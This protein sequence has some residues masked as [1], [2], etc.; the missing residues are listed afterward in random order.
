[1][2]PLGPFA[3]YGFTF[4]PFLGAAVIYDRVTRGRI[5]PA[6]LWGGGLLIA[7]VPLRLMISA[8]P[9]WQRLAGALI[10]R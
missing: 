4:I 6:Y 3:F 5:H 8:T 7:S 1:M 10:G 2:L 9:A